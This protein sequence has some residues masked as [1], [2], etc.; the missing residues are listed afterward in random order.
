M[1]SAD[2]C[3]P[4]ALPRD[5]ASH[6]RQSG[7][8]PT[9]RHGAFDRATPDLPSYASLSIGPLRPLPHYPRTLALYPVSVRRVRPLPRASFRPRL[10]TTPLPPASGSAQ[11]ARRGLSPP[12][13]TSCVAYK[14]NPVSL[15][16]TRSE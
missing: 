7:R 8:S 4:L 10:A 14:T 2:F 9:I 1:A 5:S 3:R 15:H 16:G 13:S 6:L 12:S 11:T